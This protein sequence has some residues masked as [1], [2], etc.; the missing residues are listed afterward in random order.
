MGH[1]LLTMTQFDFL[2]ETSPKKKE[3]R[4]DIQPSIKLFHRALK[5]AEER[6]LGGTDASFLQLNDGAGFLGEATLSALLVRKSY[7]GLDE[8]IHSQPL[9]SDPPS[10]IITGNPGIAFPFTNCTSALS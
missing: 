9:S 7:I 3:P 6:P 5:K 10:F 2:D 1:L 8:L 4:L